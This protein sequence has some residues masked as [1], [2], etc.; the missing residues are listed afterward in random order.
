MNLKIENK[1]E[2]ANQYLTALAINELVDLCYGNAKSA[3]WHKE[4]PPEV[5]G[6]LKC[7]QLM[8]MVSEIAESMEGERKNKMDDHLSHRKAAE[9]ELADLIIRACD[10]AGRWGYDLGGAVVE[11]LKY[12]KS[13][14]DHKPENRQKEG[15][16][17]F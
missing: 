17:K 9:V 14:L 13:R 10:Y 6:Y 5:E 8:L 16:K 3:G 15:G 11:K 7:T 4:V 1:S 12:N 2:E